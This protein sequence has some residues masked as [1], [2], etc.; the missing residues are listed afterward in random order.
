MKRGNWIQLFIRS[1]KTLRN[2]RGTP[3]VSMDIFFSKEEQ[4]SVRQREDA[5]AFQVT[6]GS[7]ISNMEKYKTAQLILKTASHLDF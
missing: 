6:L 5:G 1:S 4:I 3:N 2:A 7:S